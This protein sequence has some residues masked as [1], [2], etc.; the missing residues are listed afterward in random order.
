[1]DTKNNQNSERTSVEDKLVGLTE[2]N[3]PKP[4]SNTVRDQK[5]SP[6]I[7]V[8]HF[9]P[10]DEQIESKLVEVEKL[11]HRR[12]YNTAIREAREIKFD[13]SN[14]ASIYTLMIN[15]KITRAQVAIGDRY[16]ARGDI[17][18][19]K[20]SYKAAIKL[21]EADIKTK[22][23]AEITKNMVD[24]IQK[25][26][27]GMFGDLQQIM[28]EKEYKK[29]CDTRRRLQDTSILDF[30]PTIIPDISLT[31]VFGPQ[32]PPNWPPKDRFDK[33]WIDP[34]IVDEQLNKEQ[35]GGIILDRPTM[36][37]GA[38][39]ASMSAKP[40]NLNTIQEFSLEVGRHITPGVFDGD[41][42][43]QLR[44]S[45]TFPLMSSMLLAH[46]RLYAVESNLN[47]SGFSVGSIPIY[48][49]SY[50]IEQARKILAFI[51]EVDSKMIN[52]QFKLD[53]FNELIDTIR[54]HTDENSAELQA[55]NSRIS[56][57]QTTLSTLYKS[58]AEIGKV[59]QGL[60]T[61]EDDCGHEWWEW[62]LAIL[63]VVAG[64]VAG[65][66]AGFLLASAA[67]TGAVATTATLVGYIASGSLI[68]AATSLG[69]TIS[70]W[71]DTEITCENVTKARQDFLSTQSALQTAGKDA[72]AELNHALLQRDTIIA[73]LASLQ[74]AYDEAITSNQARVFNAM[75]LSHILGVLDS[76]RS[77]CILRAHSLAQMAQD[78]YNTENDMQVNIIATN[79]SDY[80]DKDARSYTAAAMLQ[81]DLDGLEHIRLTGRTRKNMQLTH[82]L[83]L[84][85][86]YPSAFVSLLTTGHT[87][88]S[89]RMEDFDRWFPGTYMQRLK[90]VRVEI[91]VNDK[92]HLIRGY[93]TNDGV[94][95]V[96]FPDYGN[97]IKVDERDVFTEID[98]DIRKLCYKRRRRHHTVETMAFPSFDS[99]LFEARTTEIQQQELNFFEG[100]GLESTWHLELTPDQA[101]DYDRITDVR[102]Y[103]QFES[104]F[105][106]ALKS[107][108]ETKRYKDRN[109]TAFFSVRKLLE[110]Q[111]TSVDF[112]QPI[113]VN[114][115]D[116]MFEAPNLDKTIRDVCIVLQ[117]KHTAVPIGKAE[118]SLSYQGQPVIT[119]E[120]NEQGIV[121]TADAKTAGTNT[122]ALRDLV[123]NK[124]VIG[125]WSIQINH[126]PNGIRT[127]DIEDI[128]ILTRYTFK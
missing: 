35:L 11:I 50:L 53:D 120:T 64:T 45:S 93:L 49:Y 125:K 59:V 75:T 88:F 51:T 4:M 57:L 2:V 3:I 123:Q 31:E 73:A 114:I 81:R 25:T 43:L 62:G 68:G 5:L 56:Q 34:I 15:E 77:T 112:L 32:P 83:S 127:E 18:Q 22:T 86:H 23:I 117:S 61:A 20:Q 46:T 44:A 80:L 118:L 16:L 98:E 85:K 38:S 109:E 33:G 92:P 12:S 24:Q 10:R 121:A 78:A 89:T 7:G 30:I 119:V 55:I 36:I 40:I 94:S 116:F 21:Q 76:V 97:K 14:L 128:M 110:E 111:G 1:M 90:E 48:R 42:P 91:L 9:I 26:R 99:F 27:E 105:D 13:D 104:S 47:F 41:Q 79:I 101:L 37:P 108:I 66:F 102:V 19:A 107:V 8:R 126:L 63:V 60:T 71:N 72:K 54:R 52:M 95:F 100:C 87:R 122:N 39:F 67:V 106:P 84:K 70:V 113:K 124:S 17:K 74:D 103:F 58:E 115:N 96:R 82:T 28:I 69:A 65:G 6:K 29:W